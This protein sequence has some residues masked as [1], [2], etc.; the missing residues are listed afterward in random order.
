[1]ITFITRPREVAQNKRIYKF[2]YTDYINDII[3]HNPNKHPQDT[4]F[5]NQ[6]AGL[7]SWRLVPQSSIIKKKKDFHERITLAIISLYSV[8]ALY[9]ASLVIDN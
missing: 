8:H 6:G 7:T 3:K 1:M 9:I 2:T 4:G 5:N